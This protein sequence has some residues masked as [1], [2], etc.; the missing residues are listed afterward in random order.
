MALRLKLCT[1]HSMRTCSGMEIFVYF[2]VQPSFS[3]SRSLP[4]RVQAE[5]I[6]WTL[7]AM[8]PSS[9]IFDVWA[10]P[11][12]L[13][14]SL[15]ISVHLVPVSGSLESPKDPFPCFL[16]GG[17]LYPGLVCL[18]NVLPAP[19]LC[20]RRI[21]EKRKEFGLK[22]GFVLISLIYL[23][24]WGTSWLSITLRT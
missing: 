16:L 12:L 13:D 17:D 18:L 14:D 24:P 2:L 19:V 4:C 7:E 21:L 3:V 11:W 23:Q 1:I 5:W 20:L 10:A 22:W 9:G 6:L 15:A 8:S